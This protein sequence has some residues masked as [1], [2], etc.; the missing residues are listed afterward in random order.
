MLVS[1][2]PAAAERALQA[3]VTRLPTEPV[4][5]KYLAD[6]ATRLGHQAVAADAAARYAAF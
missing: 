5:F 3:A 2:N 1:G 6:A 4:A